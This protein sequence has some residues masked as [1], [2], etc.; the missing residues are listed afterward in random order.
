MDLA[1]RLINF[2]SLRRN[3]PLLGLG[4]MS[5]DDLR[6]MLTKGD[7]DG[8]DALNEMEFCV[9]MVRLSPELM[10]EPRRWLDDAVAQASQ[11]LFTNYSD[12]STWIGIFF[13]LLFFFRLFIASG[14][15]SALLIGSENSICNY[16]LPSHPMVG[17]GVRLPLPAPRTRFS[18]FRVSLSPRRRDTIAT[19][20]KKGDRPTRFPPPSVATKKPSSAA[21]RP[22][23]RVMN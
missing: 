12:Q 11:F 7:F 15:I 19:P 9:L 20:R 1:S 2:D 6:G 13:S 4:P 18:P 10:D 23:P 14:F 3:A 8:N 21:P 22:R 16:I 5:D 17:T